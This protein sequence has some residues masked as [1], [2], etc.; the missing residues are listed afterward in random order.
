MDY[1]NQLVR[2]Y[3]CLTNKSS[4]K[5]SS[6]AILSQKKAGYFYGPTV[7][8]SVLCARISRFFVSTHNSLKSL[9]SV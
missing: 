4:Y 6:S 9:F 5:Y 8:G 7:L 1:R 3:P 2:G